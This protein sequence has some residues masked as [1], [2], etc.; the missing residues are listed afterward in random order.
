MMA[1]PPPIKVPSC[2]NNEVLTGKAGELSC[3][4]VSK[5]NQTIIQ[6][7]ADLMKVFTQLDDHEQRLK[8]LEM[9][10]GGGGGG[11]ATFAGVTKYTSP[12]LITK[13]NF[14]NGLVA[15]AARCTDEYGA[16]AHMCTV[17]E[18]Y[19]SVITGKVVS[20]KPSPKAWVYAPSWQRA[21]MT[22]SSHPLLGVSDNCAGYTYPTGDQGFAG[23][24]FEWGPSPAKNQAATY[25]PLWHGGSMNAACSAVLPIAC[26]K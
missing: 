16:G 24:A 17:G 25:V 10:M 15:A 13:P 9:M 20:G 11:I 12:G 4:D 26:C 19:Q 7:V 2:L 8:K 23:V 1:Q 14:D 3:V 5:V 18:I 6:V 22:G 21:A